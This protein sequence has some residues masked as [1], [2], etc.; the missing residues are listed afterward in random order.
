MYENEG[1]I[2]PPKMKLDQFSCFDP[3]KPKNTKR[4]TIIPYPNYKKS[5]MPQLTPQNSIDNFAQQ[6]SHSYQKL[7]K[8]VII[9]N[10]THLLMKLSGEE[11][12]LNSLTS[13]QLELYFQLRAQERDSDKANKLINVQ[14]NSKQL[15]IISEIFLE[16]HNIP[17]RKFSEN[18]EQT[19]RIKQEE[20][21]DHDQNKIYKLFKQDADVDILN[22][23]VKLE[24]MKAME[25]H[26]IG[27]CGGETCVHLK[28][29]MAIKQKARGAPY[30]LKRATI[31]NVRR[32]P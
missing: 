30:P 7:R 22:P 13:E 2:E 9:E 19:N 14:E 17:P 16:V 31:A 4:D 20:E 29:A 6:Q 32:Y 23:N 28:R 21:K 24:L 12:F 3:I 15:Q 25:G 27:K 10:S 26:E 1:L 11:N 18:L 5:L 8:Q